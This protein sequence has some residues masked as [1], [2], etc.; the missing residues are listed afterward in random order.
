MNKVYKVC[1]CGN[2]F[3]ISR[4][5]QHIKSKRHQKYIQDGEKINYEIIGDKIQCRCRSILKGGSFQE[6]S[7]SISNHQR[8]PRH[9]R[10][11]NTPIGGEFCFE[12]RDKDF[13]VIEKVTFIK[14]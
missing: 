3:N 12:I 5:Q 1:D 13:M 4:Q 10:Y 11:E 9:Q 2:E 7:S 6:Q 14:E 8:T